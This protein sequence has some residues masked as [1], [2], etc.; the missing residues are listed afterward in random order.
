YAREQEKIHDKNFR[1]T[2][3]TNGLLLSDDKLEYINKNMSNIVL[4]IDGRKS[5]NDKVR[6]RADGTGS[7]DTIVPKFQKVAE[8]R[9]QDNYYVRGTFTKYNLDFSKDVLHLADLGF[10]QTSVE[11]VVCSGVEDYALSKEDL[12]KIYNEYELLVEEYLNRKKNGN[13]FNFF[14]FMI[15]LDQG[16]CVIKRLSGCG[17]GCEYLAIAPNGDIYPCH[18]FV[19]TEEYKMGNLNDGNINMNIR[20]KFENCN[21]YTKPKCKD[22]FAKFYCS[23][24]CMANACLINGDIN[25]PHEISCDIQRKRVECSLYAKAVE[26]EF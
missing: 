1:F 19:G 18:Q 13:G 4:S 26:A 17:A 14:H 10:K 9:N 20:Q 24:G 23:G 11:P 12:P 15:D 6:Y 21:V 7:Y 22:C 5:V 3:T 2:I 25:E 16:P 8:S